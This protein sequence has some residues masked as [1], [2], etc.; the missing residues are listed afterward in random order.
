MRRLAL[1]FLFATMVTGCGVH[2]RAGV[3]HPGPAPLPPA[4]PP[5]HQ[6]ARVVSAPEIR[7]K[8]IDTDYV[9][10]RVIYAKEVRARGGRIAR[11]EGWD[12]DDGHRGRGKGHG[13]GKGR[14]HSKG[15]GNG[16]GFGWG[17]QEL[18]VPEVRA[19]V[20]YVKELNARWIDADLI[21]AQ[22]VDIGR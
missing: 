5:A 22:E 20:I 13:K 8:E 17:S 11:V 10:A 6:H 16:N 18:S 19:D 21:V 9:R 4:P 2:V 15:H 14:G 1:A 3:P 7:A 12:D